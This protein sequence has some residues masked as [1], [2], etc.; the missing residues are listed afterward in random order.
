V[1]RG[2]T[3]QT[4]LSMRWFDCVFEGIGDGSIE[5]MALMAGFDGRKRLGGQG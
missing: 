2:W 4:D 3:A 5:L 1:A